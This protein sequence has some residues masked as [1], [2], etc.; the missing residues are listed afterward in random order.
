[1]WI[2]LT[3]ERSPEVQPRKFKQARERHSNAPFSLPR[4]PALAETGATARAAAQKTI[5]NPDSTNGLRLIAPAAVEL[6]VQVWFAVTAANVE[7]RAAPAP[8]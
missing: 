3:P 1:M 8:P 4:L 6:R 7:S 5:N 2:V